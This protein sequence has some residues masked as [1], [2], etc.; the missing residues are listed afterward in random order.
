LPQSQNA[1]AVPL[2]DDPQTIVVQFQLGFLNCLDFNAASW[3]G[4]LGPI[5]WTLMFAWIYIQESL[6][7]APRV[8]PPAFS[9]LQMLFYF[10][11][12]IIVI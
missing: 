1:D 2:A 6:Y 11:L 10:L 8:H 3:L 7:P 12:P 5:G 4:R 9:N